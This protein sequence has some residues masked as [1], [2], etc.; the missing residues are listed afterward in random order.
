MIFR[1]LT[2][3]LKRF[4]SNCFLSKSMKIFPETQVTDNRLLC[5]SFYLRWQLKLNSYWNYGWTV[6]FQVFEQKDGTVGY[7][8]SIGIKMLHARIASKLPWSLHGMLIARLMHS[9]Q[10]PSILTILSAGKSWGEH[11]FDCF[12]FRT[13][14]RLIYTSE[15]RPNS[16]RKWID[17]KI[18]A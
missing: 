9:L 4:F 18:Y 15:Y 16:F 12:D 17:A 14:H 5:N 3:N 1:K 10:I 2:K 7:F 8:C 11:N 13:C 6:D